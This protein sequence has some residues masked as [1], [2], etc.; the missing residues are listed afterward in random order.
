MKMLGDEQVKLYKEL[1]DKAKKDAV[2]NKD[3]IDEYEKLKDEK[4][5]LQGHFRVINESEFGRCADWAMT[6]YSI[7]A[8]IKALSEELSGASCL[9]YC[10]RD[11]AWYLQI[12]DL[13]EYYKDR[14]SSAIKDIECLKAAIERAEK[15]TKE[16]EKKTFK[17]AK[18]FAS[19][20]DD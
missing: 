6:E 2:D 8:T 16:K 12:I 17:T 10:N 11:I 3:I 15:A 20:K 4:Y 18:W 13:S 7:G 9:N 19:K 1:L 5:L 14:V